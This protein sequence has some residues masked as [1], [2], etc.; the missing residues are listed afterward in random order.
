M[1]YL[2]DG[3]LLMSNSGGTSTA[4]RV[5]ISLLRPEDGGP[6][7]VERRLVDDPAFDLHSPSVSPDGRVVARGRS[8]SWGGGTIPRAFTALRVAR[9]QLDG[10]AGGSASTSRCA[11]GRAA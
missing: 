5:V 10:R 7:G 11:A 6:S 8:V 9:R 2:P 3:R 4:G 1:D